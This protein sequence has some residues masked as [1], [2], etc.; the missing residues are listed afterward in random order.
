MQHTRRCGFQLNYSYL[1]TFT[2]ASCVR[3]FGVGYRMS[4]QTCTQYER[5]EALLLVSDVVGKTAGYEM[6]SF[7][8]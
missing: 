3:C 6:K 5:R 8:H 7:L 2:I 4:F 1:L